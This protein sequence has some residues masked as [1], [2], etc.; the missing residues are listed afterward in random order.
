MTNPPRSREGAARAA[1]LPRLADGRPAAL[2]A[3][4]LEAMTLA[5]RRG[6]LGQCWGG[7]ER[8]FGKVQQVQVLRDQEGWRK[9]QKSPK[10]PQSRSKTLLKCSDEAYRALRLLQR[11]ST[12]STGNGFPCGC[13]DQRPDNPR[14]NDLK[15][16]GVDRL[17]FYDIVEPET[18]HRQEEV[19]RR[20]GRSASR[21]TRCGEAA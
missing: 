7:K 20:G 14:I 16:A 19:R 21:L 4:P 10:R 11:T 15:M 3:K 1:V 2:H 18:R 8:T 17:T 12:N 9:Q 5:M 13:T 6:T